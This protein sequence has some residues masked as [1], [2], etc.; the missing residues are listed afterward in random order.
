MENSKILIQKKAQKALNK[1]FS[2]NPPPEAWNYNHLTLVS[3]ENIFECWLSSKLSASLS[4]SSLPKNERLLAEDDDLALFF[5]FQLFFRLFFELVTQIRHKNT[6]ERKQKNIFCV[7]FPADNQ[8]LENIVKRGGKRRRR[9]EICDI[10]LFEFALNL[11]FSL[12]Y[13]LPSLMPVCWFFFSRVNKRDL[14]RKQFK[15]EKCKRWSMNYYDFSLPLF[16][17]FEWIQKWLKK[18]IKI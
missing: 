10:D 9:N 15:R 2:Q 6:R 18:S 11:S 17:L 12:F 1:F 14:I 16:Y 8:T 7:C 3:Y 5:R 13:S 4:L